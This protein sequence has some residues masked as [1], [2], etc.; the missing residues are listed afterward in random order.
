MPKQFFFVFP[1]NRKPDPDFFT[2]KPYRDQDE[3][4]DIRY[5]PIGS[6]VFELLDDTQID[7]QTSCSFSIWDILHSTYQDGEGMLNC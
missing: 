1:A 7:K 3:G 2:L 4:N 6:A 5:S